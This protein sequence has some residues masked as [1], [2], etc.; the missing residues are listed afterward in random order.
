[1]K[2]K[3]SLRTELL[4]NLTILA[5]AALVLAA[6]SALVAPLLGDDARGGALLLLLIVADLAV[7]VVFG[8]YLVTRLVTR[9]LEELV[10]ATEAVAAGELHR[11]APAADTEE[12]DRLAQSVNRM[13]D[14]LLDVQGALVRAEKLASVGRLAAGI[15]HEVGNPL[16]AIGN[17][18]EIL[19]RHGADPST[20]QALEH[21]AQRIDAIVR[22]L[23]EYSRP[24]ESAFEPLH[25][26]NVLTD[27][28]QLLERQGVLREVRH[29][30]AV[31]PHAPLVLGDRQA[32]QQLCV[33]LLLNAVDAAGAGGKLAIDVR[34]RDGWAALAV[35]DSGPGV[36]E[37]LR[38]QVFDPFFTTKEPGK[39]TGLGLAIVQRI[40]EDHGGRILIEDS[41]LGGASFVITLPAHRS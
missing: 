40:V 8:R 2:R 9:P 10:R 13:T 15:A 23:L 27:T 39:G 6:G 26:G 22:G 5:A 35:A 29:E 19:R 14:R 32:L 37:P 41:P 38:A 25:L 18:V 36:P 33:N 30:V 17:Y 11:R 1:M 21:E 24:R 12:L 31:D 34:A 28:V 16:A 4:V 20:V 7:L 3:P